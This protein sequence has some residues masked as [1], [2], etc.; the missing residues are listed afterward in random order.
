[1]RDELAVLS[2]NLLQL[3]VNIGFAAGVADRHGVRA[4]AEFAPV[5]S[6]DLHSAALFGLGRPLAGACRA[7]V[8]PPLWLDEWL[9]QMCHRCP[10][11]KFVFHLEI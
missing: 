2:Q 6:A 3:G 9:D 7:G 8:A 11:E 1:M 10:R 4:G 5:V